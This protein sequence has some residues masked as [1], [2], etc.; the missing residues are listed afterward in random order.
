MKYSFKRKNEISLREFEEQMREQEKALRWL[1]SGQASAD[2]TVDYVRGIMES[3][4]PCKRMPD[5]L[6]W[7]FDEPETMPADSR[8]LY[9]YI[10]TYLNTVFMMQAFRMFPENVGAVPRFANALRRAMTASAGEDLLALIIQRM[11]LCGG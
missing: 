7:G 3:G 1:M 5:S 2:D 10:P 9:Y 8:V 11:I 4:R 6:F